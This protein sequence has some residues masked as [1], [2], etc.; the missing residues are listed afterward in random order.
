MACN[1]DQPSQD[2]LKKLLDANAEA[3]T[4][5]IDKSIDSLKESMSIVRAEI[6]TMKL[7]VETTSRQMTETKEKCE[8]LEAELIQTESRASDLSEKNKRSRE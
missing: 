8:S 4:V 7:S 3:L 5:H 1:I 6:S 2:W